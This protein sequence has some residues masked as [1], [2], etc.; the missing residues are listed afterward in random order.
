MSQRA[1]EPHS[2]AARWIR[3]QLARLLIGAGLGCLALYGAAKLDARI[4][5]ARAERF[6][7]LNPNPAPALAATRLGPID[8]PPAG[9]AP[10][11]APARVF[12]ESEIPPGTPIAR[13]R[14]PRLALAVTVFAG[15]DALALNRGLGHVYGTAAPGS[16]GNVALAG[17]RDSYFRGL[18]QLVP[19]DLVALDTANGSYDYRVERS[20]V[21]T[22]DRTEVLAPSASPRLTLV[23]CYPFDW[24]GP[25][26]QRYVV[27]TSPATAVMPAASTRDGR[28]HDSTRSSSPSSH[29][30]R[31]ASRAP[32]SGGSERQTW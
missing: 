28:L 8:P 18:G 27:F 20:E 3:L 1:R 16:A 23:T 13:L 7:T 17:H 4:A 30:R 32:G 22:P 25:A 14:I 15:T 11:L 9:G 26:P 19:G 12:E 24:V 2:P 10:A 5:Q 21:V 29:P 31:P 6:L